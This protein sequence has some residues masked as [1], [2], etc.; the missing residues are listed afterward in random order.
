MLYRERAEL[1]QIESRQI[2][3]GWIRQFGITMVIYLGALAAATWSLTSVP[4]GPLRTA[5]VL[6]PILPGLA[7]IGLTVHSYRLNDEYIRLR[8]LQSAA[9]AVLVVAVFSLIYSFLE[10]L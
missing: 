9:V 7:L 3:I 4:P 5:L 10:L 2:L 1:M 8:T 6:A